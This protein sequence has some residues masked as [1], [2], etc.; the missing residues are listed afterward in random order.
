M[1]TADLASETIDFLA[2]NPTAVDPFD[3]VLAFTFA[4]FVDGIPVTPRGYDESEI[5]SEAV[6]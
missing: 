1:T 5:F 4:T 2:D 6:L 3:E